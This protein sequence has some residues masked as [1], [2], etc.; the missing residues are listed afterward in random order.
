MNMNSK[1]RYL[2]I[3]IF[4]A[5]SQAEG[6][7]ADANRGASESAD[8]VTVP[9]EVQ[10][11]AYASAQV[12]PRIAAQIMQRHVRLGD[13]IK[14]GVPLVT[15]S[16]VEMAE[17]QG[18]LMLADAEWNRVQKLGKDV[19]SERRYVEAQTARQLAYA[20]VIAYGM[21]REQ[22]EQLLR[23][24]DP[25]RADGSFALVAPRAGRIILDDFIEGKLAEPGKVLFEITDES[26]LW[27]QVR[28]SP[29]QATSVRVGTP[30]RVRA[31]D[32]WLTGRVI[33]TMHRLDEQTRTY[34]VRGEVRNIGDALHSGQFVD[35]R[36]PIKA[37]P[38]GA[39][40]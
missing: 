36:L 3:G 12:T 30:L 10:L 14:A 27:V 26:M 16:S 24:A 2:L 37:T 31:G 23:S 38:A 13:E 29:A 25:A 9:G 15:L 21:T 34:T 28:L 22:A 6:F 32:T 39:A 8:E 7:A 11:N 5:L 4:L 17:A 18:A 33:Q 1:T 20:K 19:V 35:V 40:P